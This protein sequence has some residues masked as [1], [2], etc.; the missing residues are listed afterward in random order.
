MSKL[1]LSR[2]Q[3]QIVQAILEDN[4]CIQLDFYP[5]FRQLQVGDIYLGRVQK[6]VGNIQSAFIEL[7]SGSIGYYAMDPLQPLKP[8]QEILVQLIKEPIKTKAAV[9]STDLSLSGKFVVLHENGGYIAVSS[10]IEKKKVR[11]SFRDLLSPLCKNENLPSGRKAPGFIVRTN[12]KNA[13]FDQILQEAEFLLEQYYQLI[14]QADHR[15]C[16]TCIH[17]APSPYLASI[18][19]IYNTANMEVITDQPDLYEEITKYFATT[20]GLSVPSVSFYQDQLLP[21]IKLYRLETILQKSTNRQVWL[22]SGGYLI[23]EPTEAMVVID[24][25]TGKFDSKK[26]TED[27]FLSINRE[28]AREIAKQIRLRNLSGII[29]IDFI[30]MESQEAQ[31]LLLEELQSYIHKDPVKTVFVDMTKL[32]LVELTRKKIRKPLHEQILKEEKVY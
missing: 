11:E 18:R 31:N 32:G 30:D 22:K 20:K 2:M 21:L 8:G 7:I 3:G 27:T 13:C 19:D 16:F 5:D 28:A 9:L 1:I 6:I 24:V 25:N 10:K 12:A 26:K 14:H 15:P 29:I 17:S 23:I 4:D